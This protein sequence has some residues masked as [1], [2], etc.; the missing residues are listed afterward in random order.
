MRIFIGTCEIASHYGVIARELRK[1]GHVVSVFGPLLYE[2]DRRNLNTL[3]FP[4]IIERLVLNSRINLPKGARFVASKMLLTLLLFWICLRVDCVLLYGGSSFVALPFDLSLLRFF[5]K[6]I[7]VNCGH[8][9]E[10]RPPYINSKYNND[11][12][13]SYSLT[14]HIYMRVRAIERHSH[15]IIGLPVLSQFFVRNLVHRDLIGKPVDLAYGTHDRTFA[16]DSAGRERPTRIC[17]IPSDPLS[18]GTSDIRKIVKELGRFGISPENYCYVEYRDLKRNEVINALRNSDLVITQMF[19]DIATPTTALEAAA[20]G[21][22]AIVCGNAAEL[23]KVR[24]G[25]AVSLY[26][27]PERLDIVLARLIGNQNLIKRLAGKYTKQYIEDYSLGRC[28]ANYERLFIGEAPD[29]WFFDP[30]EYSYCWGDGLSKEEAR[31]RINKY[32]ERYGLPAL[33]INHNLKLEA[34]FKDMQGGDRSGD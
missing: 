22:L 8:G 26:I 14:K 24:H 30:M 20:V 34:M 6:K 18:K 9:S 31:R 33:Y 25:R 16:S 1:R 4:K 13:K 7:I 5:R 32:I 12:R 27:S 23:E 17:H 10:S 11:I 28:V 21:C 3:W 2:R 19:S 15:A 29:E